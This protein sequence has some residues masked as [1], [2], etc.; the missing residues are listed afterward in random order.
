[1]YK[2]IVRPQLE[3]LIQAWRP[4]H[5]KDIDTLERICM[6]IENMR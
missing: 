3:Y 6:K 1:M 5:E 2:A 4:Y